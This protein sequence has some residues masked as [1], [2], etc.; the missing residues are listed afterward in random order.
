MATSSPT[1][2]FYGGIG[3]IGGTKIVVQEGEYRV[4]FDFGLNYAPG[5]D[6]WGGNLQP[7]RGPGRLRDLVALGYTPAL[8]GLYKEGYA[9][10][11]G[12]TAGTDDKTQVFISHL[13]LDHMAAV[14]IL[15]DA[16]P[17]WMHED[18]L[19][20]FRAVAEVGEQPPVPVDSR[21][22]RWGEPIEV[23]PIKVTPVAVDHDIPGASALLIETS[24]GTV[25]Y[26]GD[27]RTH[28]ARP[29]RIAEFIAAARAKNPQILLIEGT[30]LGEPEPTPERPPTTPEPEVAQ[31]A[32]AQALA[33]RGLA[34]ITLYPRNTL[35]IANIVAA[36]KG[37]ERR[38]VLSPEVAHIYAAMG[39]D[40]SEVALFKRHKD[41]D[42]LANGTAP[43]W[44]RQLFAGGHQVLDAEAIRA[45]QS[46]Y[47]LQLFFSDFTELVDLQPAEGSVFIHSN[48]EPLGRFDPSYE[49]FTR[50]LDRFG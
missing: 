16:V 15:A 45:N 22:F 37:T 17:V 42:E 32:A 48:G 36:L 44:L 20:L 4:V 12:L 29:E 28:G 13:H 50:W 30:R 31:K 9:Q 6:F 35:R 46:H 14:D 34:M 38:M 7:R 24:A 49:L 27:L 8:N 19:R 3:T 11:L 40:L 2:Q 25:V 26:S 5:G 39:G 41:Q 47:L 21:G 33:A 23:G 1:I 43:E 10:S 18:S